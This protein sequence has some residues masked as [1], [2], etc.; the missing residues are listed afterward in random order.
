MLVMSHKFLFVEVVQFH[1]RGLVILS[2]LVGTA[3][4]LTRGSASAPITTGDV[5][6]AAEMRLAVPQGPFAH[7]SD[8]SYAVVSSAWL[9]Q[10]YKRWRADLS[11]QGVVKWDSRFDC[12]RFVASFCATAQMEFFR[13]TFHSRV[14]A[15][16]LA[17]GELWYTQDG[18]GP[19]AVVV[20]ITEEGTVFFEPQTGEILTLRITELASIGFKRF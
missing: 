10:F 3:G 18:V 4:C 7:V 8:E 9:G 2:L 20:A 6:S 11:R 17:V 12:N 19:H 13:N 1:L 14:Q 16:A 15:Q 5:L